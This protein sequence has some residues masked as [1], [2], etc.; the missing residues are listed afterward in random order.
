MLKMRL[1]TTIAGI[2]SSLIISA[3]G[4]A[5]AE[6]LRIGGTGVALGGMTLLGA[7]FEKQNPGTEVVVLPSL[8]SSGGVKALIAGAIDLSVSSRAL[9]DAEEAKGAQGTLYATTPL[10]LV[11][12][13]ITNAD[14]VTTESLAQIYSGELTE[15]SSGEPI[16]LVL[17]PMSETDTKIVGGLSDAVMQAIEGAHKRPGLLKATND[18]ENAE[19]LEHLAGSLGAVAMGQIATENRSL[20][21]L[22]LNG[23]SPKP[24]DISDQ[25]LAF[26]K[27]LYIV[28]TG[29]PSDLASQFFDFIF[30]EEARSILVA[31][32]H[33]PAR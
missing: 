3:C 33:A 10:A 15:W 17:R 9:K 25:D 31:T 30:S 2:I 16:R 29:S 6:T 22:T 21:I 8:G 26:S 28:K 19:M 4:V 1:T 13:S 14:A 5:Q 7:A 27:S 20:K 18:Q 32:D 11:T 12:S 23:I 24:G